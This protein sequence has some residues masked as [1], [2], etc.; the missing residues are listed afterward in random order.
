LNS[1]GTVKSGRVMLKVADKPDLFQG[2]FP[3][4]LVIKGRGPRF[5]FV[6]FRTSRYD[7]ASVTVK[8]VAIPSW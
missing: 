2:P 3:R 7:A 8:T 6:R 4:C 5:L 1:A